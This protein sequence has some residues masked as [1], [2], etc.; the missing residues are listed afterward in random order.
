MSTHYEERMEADLAEIKRKVRKVSD[1]VE[2]QVQRAVEAFLTIPSEQWALAKQELEE[3]ERL[4]GPRRGETL[5][6]Q[7]LSPTKL[8]RPN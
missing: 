8:Q 7:P 1:L 6:N 3:N 2:L 4:R 5:L